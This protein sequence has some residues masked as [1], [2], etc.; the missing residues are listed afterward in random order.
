MIASK[1]IIAHLVGAGAEIWNDNA[2][3]V[4]APPA[5]NFAPVTESTRRSLASRASFESIQRASNAERSAGVRSEPRED[6]LYC[7]KPNGAMSV[8][9]R[10]WGCTLPLVEITS[11]LLLP[12]GVRTLMDWMGGR[13]EGSRFC[14]GGGAIACDA[15]VPT[16]ALHEARSHSFLSRKWLW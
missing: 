7:G 4:A 13:S 16:W 8:A 14:H 3:I 6:P 5:H 15:F 10:F 11:H 1:A 2:G 12:I 9:R